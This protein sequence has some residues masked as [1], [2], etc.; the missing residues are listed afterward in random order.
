MA[1]KKIR[2]KSAE[3]A[4][5]RKIA[6]HGESI[7]GWSTAAG[8]RRAERRAALL[9]EL[10]AL[11]SQQR[12]LELGCGTGI[13]T[14]KLAGCGAYLTA[15]DISAELLS[16]AQRRLN[17]VKNATLVLA[18]GESLPFHDEMFDAVVGSSIL[19]HLPLK[20]SLTEIRRIL[21]PGGKLAFAEPNMMNPQIL[22]QKNVP[23]VKRWLGDSPDESAFIRWRLKRKLL[24][25]GFEN[26]VI[27]PYDFL[28][29]LTPGLA[30]PLV[31]QM[32]RLAE[33][34]PILRQI[35]GSLI[36]GASRR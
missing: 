33:K 3:I 17:G 31:D 21:R 10:S 13:F 32:G 27:K 5:S 12:V 23:V 35:A 36:I 2:S 8:R 14:D 22:I 25:V 26:I 28:H 4:H 15:V 24:S 29:P 30:V 11:T 20:S 18:D 16:W 6:E 9:V 19:H 7:W 1:E 34:I